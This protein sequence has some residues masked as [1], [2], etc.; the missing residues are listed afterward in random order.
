ME[1]LDIPALILAGGLGTRLRTVLDVP[2]V[3]APIN[4]KPFMYYI[5]GQLRAA[6]I[7]RAILCTGHRADEV[8]AELGEETGGVNLSYSREPHPLGTAG[9]LRLAI[10]KIDSPR[11][12]VFNG[13]SVCRVDVRSLVKAHSDSLAAITMVVV[14]SSVGHVSMDEQ[15]RVTE[16]SEKKQWCNAGVYVMQRSVIRRL[17]AETTLSLEH[18]ILAKCQNIRGFV[19]RDLIDIGTPESYARSVECLG[20]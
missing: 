10:E 17:P 4:G 13:D 19:G 7:S 1:M 16:F 15:M 5:L 8:E 14:K 3:L 20:R 18:D 9:A 11:F 12:L 2:K 6:G